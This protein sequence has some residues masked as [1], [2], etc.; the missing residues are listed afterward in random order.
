MRKKESKDIATVFQKRIRESI[1]IAA[2]AERVWSE[3]P[4]TG[5]VG[6]A[7]LP[8]AWALHEPQPNDPAIWTAVGAGLMWGAALV[9]CQVG[10]T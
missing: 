7:S 1:R 2:P 9:G 8:I 5:N 10:R 4:R 6:A 3:T